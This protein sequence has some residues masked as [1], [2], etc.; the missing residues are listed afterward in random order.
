MTVSFSAIYEEARVAA[1]EAGKKWL[2][3]ALARGPTF[4]VID[5]NP[6]LT[7][8][9]EVDGGE[10]VI[11]AR[12][13]V[14]QLLDA[15]GIAYVRFTDKRTAFYKWY[16]KTHMGTFTTSACRFNTTNRFRQEWGLHEAETRAALAVLNKHGI[17]GVT[18]YSN[19][20]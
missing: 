3:E 18:M 11:E 13:V 19:I 5:H 17:R 8:H 12:R 16:K 20:D 7:A 14:G 4:L 15:C 9:K 6:F 1:D 10:E 2:E